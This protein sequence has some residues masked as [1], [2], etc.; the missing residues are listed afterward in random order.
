MN[1]QILRVSSF[2]LAELP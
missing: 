2:H 1:D